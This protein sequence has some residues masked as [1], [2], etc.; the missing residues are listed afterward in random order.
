MNH[1]NA[2]AFNQAKQYAGGQV[3]ITGPATMRSGT[4]SLQVDA[5]AAM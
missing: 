5:V 3:K 1:D 2:D 4:R